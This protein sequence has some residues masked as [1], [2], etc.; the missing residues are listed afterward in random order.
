MKLLCPS[1]E[2]EHEIRSTQQA[3][4]EFDCPYT[5]ERVAIPGTP[6]GSDES[7]RTVPAHEPHDPPSPGP[8]LGDPFSTSVN[9]SGVVLELP[10][11]QV[12]HLGPHSSLLLGRSPEC[13]FSSEMPDNVSRRHATIEVSSVGATVT[14]HGSSNGT[15]VDGRRLDVDVPTPIGQTAH[16]RLGADPAVEI[17][18]RNV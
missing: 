5:G 17:A 6:S 10:W 11:G 18:A 12:V 2:S 14:D 13:P 7:S 9:G 16:V 1:C 3:A 4:G 8:A 15:W